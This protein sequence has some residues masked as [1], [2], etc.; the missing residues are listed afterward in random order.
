M[1]WASEGK[2]RSHGSFAPTFQRNENNVLA[3]EV[4]IPKIV[5]GAQTGADRGGAGLGIVERYRM[6]R[7]ARKGARRKT[8]E[9]TE[10][11]R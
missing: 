3:V 7:R 8:D 2:S 10:N 5:S 4:Y 9:S 11:I 1:V 6:R